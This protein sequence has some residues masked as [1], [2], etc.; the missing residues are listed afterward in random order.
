MRNRKSELSLQAGWSS[1][2]ANLSKVELK[3][4]LRISPDFTPEYYCGNKG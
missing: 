3:N 2:L 1:F 4:L